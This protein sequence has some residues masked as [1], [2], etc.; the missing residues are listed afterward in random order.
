MK[1]KAAI[2]DGSGTPVVK[3][4][5]INLEPPR[6]DEILVR[7]VSVGICHTDLGM[8]SPLSM[9]PAPIVLGHEGAGV[10]EA[11]GTEVS[12]FSVGDS[13]ILSIDNCGIC[14]SC[15]DEN[16]AYCEEMLLRHFSGGRPDGS[17]PLSQDG[18]RVNGNFFAQSSFA[19]HAIAPAS[20]AVK[21][22][23]EVPLALMAPLGCGIQTGAGTVF[24]ILKPKPGEGIA[25]FGVGTVGLSAIMAARIANCSPIIAIDIIPERL[26][27]ARELGANILINGQEDDALEI[28]K[29]ATNQRG[30]EYSFDTTGQ[31]KIIQQ[32][33]SSLYKNG[34]CVIAVAYD[35]IKINGMELILGK[36]I[37]GTLEGQSNPRQFIPHLISLYQAGK[38]PIDRLVKYYDFDNINKALDDAKNGKTIK[39]ILLFK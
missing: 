37:R 4:E 38:L 21:I 31:E 35:D 23:P 33:F 7:L 36:S 22:S 10:V 34:E 25:V 26:E 9:V 11:I 16:P 12:E 28:I 1:T 19:N 6:A 3:I 8:M 2:Y 39:P 17:S 13:V 15:N 32:A 30:I 5:T 27:L 18:N 14:A 29:T 20:A 24:N